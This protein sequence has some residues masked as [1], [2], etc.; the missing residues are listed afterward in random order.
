MLQQIIEVKKTK[1]ERLEESATKITEGIKS[2]NIIEV[3]TNKFDFSPEDLSTFMSKALNGYDKKYGGKTGAPKFP[4]PNDDCDGV[5]QAFTMARQIKPLLNFYYAGNLPVYAT[6]SIYSG[7]IASRS[8]QDLND[9]VFCDMPWILD[10]AIKSKKIHKT[11]V[12]KWPKKYKQNPRLFALGVDAYKISQQLD[13]LINFSEIGL[14]GMTGIL[15]LDDKQQIHRQ[16]MWAKF[17]NGRA[18]LLVN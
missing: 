2:T 14:S 10:K 17:K 12:E 1:P 7:F 8:N 6:S 11:I 15:K 18:K 4:F 13:Q 16:L 9:I 5:R 3:N